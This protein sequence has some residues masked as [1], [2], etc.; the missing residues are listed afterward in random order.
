LKK[1]IR[2][3]TWIKMSF[4]VGSRS[5]QAGCCFLVLVLNFFQNLEPMV[6]VF[7][8]SQNDPT[9]M[10][11]PVSFRMNS[12]SSQLLDMLQALRLGQFFCF[13]SLISSLPI[14]KKKS[15][16]Q[17][18]QTLTTYLHPIKNPKPCYHSRAK[19]MLQKTVL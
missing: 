16:A 19:A 9:P 1:Q 14:N 18:L 6:Q 5:V 11:A 10:I 4:W 7:G 15:T 2:I 13:S 12:S 17:T 3:E 8:N